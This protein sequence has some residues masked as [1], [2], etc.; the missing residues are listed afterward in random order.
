MA[1]L[2]LA[3]L[4][5]LSGWYATPVR[6]RGTLTVELQGAEGAYGSAM[7]L[8]ANSFLLNTMQVIL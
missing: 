3:A 8:F 5:L 4:T 1:F 2:I 7:S 6:Y